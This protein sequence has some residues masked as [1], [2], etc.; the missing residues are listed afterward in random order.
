[1]I[2]VPLDAMYTGVTKQI[3]ITRK[4]KCTS[5]KLKT[6]ESC[7]GQGRCIRTVQL[8]PNTMTQTIV[9]C[10]NCQ[11]KGTCNSSCKVCQSDGFV[12][13]PKDVSFV[14]PPGCA[15]NHSF[16]FASSGDQNADGSFQDVEIRVQSQPHSALK[17]DGADLILPVKLSLYESLTGF[18]LTHTHLNG[19]TYRLRFPEKNLPCHAGTI[20]HKEG[21]GFTS[22]GK[23][24]ISVESI[25][26][27][28]HIDLNFRQM[29]KTNWPMQ[30]RDDTSHVEN[31]SS[32]FYEEMGA[33][34]HSNC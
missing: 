12:Q 31:G 32:D 6:C 16:R 26:Y 29:L 13:E 30:I 25:I 9:P 8:G 23:L 4:L 33:P 10:T 5:C 3:R 21:L 18:A 19:K 22:R 17:R 1:M 34:K 27:P 24:I 15:E 20:I 7:R 11:G 14:I 28:K 2:N